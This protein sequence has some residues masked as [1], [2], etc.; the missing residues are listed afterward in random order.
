MPAFGKSSLQSIVEQVRPDEIYNLGAQS[1]V[2]VSFD[3]PE[4]TGEVTGLGAIR[5]LE[6]IRK[7]RLPCRYYQASSSEMFGGAPPPQSEATPLCPRSPYAA[8]KAYG[9][10]VTRSYREAYGLFA[11]M[12]TE[13]R[14][15][16]IEGS[17]DGG[18]WRR[19]QFRWKPDAL[20]RRPR[21]TPFHMPRLD[22][23][24]WFAALGRCQRQH[25]LLAMFERLLKGEPSVLGLFAHNPFPRTAP[26]YLRT[27]S[28]S[29]HF[30]PDAGWLKGEWWVSEPSPEYCPPVALRGGRLVAARFDHH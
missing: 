29:Y 11:V 8:A 30:A 27:P 13:R 2:R 5:L 12:T 10:H 26:R 23:Q 6:A 19:Y 24:M 21:F 28:A 17:L 1:H 25:W 18:E 3:I 20:D 9:Y 16:A 7:I 4:Y 22:W 14:E 15:I